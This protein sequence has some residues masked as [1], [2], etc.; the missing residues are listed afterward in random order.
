MLDA[1]HKFKASKEVLM[2]KLKLLLASIMLL[3]VS[4]CS[5][6]R[7]VP[8]GLSRG[9]FYGEGILLGYV[10]LDWTIET[11]CW[12]PLPEFDIGKV[13]VPINPTVVYGTDETYLEFNIG[14]VPMKGT[15]TSQNLTAT[16]SLAGYAYEVNLENN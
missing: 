11:S 6:S 9:Y 1:F 14:A 13:C 8:Y 10:E 12:T 15:Y 16:G 3:L 7:V 2:L 5:D 4:A